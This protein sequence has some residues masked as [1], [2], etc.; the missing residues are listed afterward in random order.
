MASPERLAAAR[1]YSYSQR[2]GSEACSRDDSASVARHTETAS[3]LGLFPTWMRPLQTE[4]SPL[5]CPVQGIPAL[6]LLTVSTCRAVR[7]IGGLPQRC[8]QNTYRDSV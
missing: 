7:Q 4:T 3:A 6:S 2:P 8:C 5:R 1:G